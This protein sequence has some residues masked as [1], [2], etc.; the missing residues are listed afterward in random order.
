MIKAVF[1][2]FYGTLA[3][4]DCGIFTSEDVCSYKPDSGLFRYALEKTGLLPD[5]VIHIGDSLV[6]DVR[7]AGS[8]GIKAV[9]LNRDGREVPVGVTSV[10][11]LTEL[12]EFL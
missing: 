3:H 11:V 10:R 7:G 12:F 8:A 2:D 1:T 6:S 4:E 5:E 9:W